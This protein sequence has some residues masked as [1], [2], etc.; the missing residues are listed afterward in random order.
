MHL[1]DSF[2][3]QGQRCGAKE[4]QT[5]ALFSYLRLED[6]VPADHPLRT[7]RTVVDAALAELSR[8]FDKLYAR[9]G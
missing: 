1:T 6:R 4:P 2:F 9:D 8:T 7:I 5:A 3:E